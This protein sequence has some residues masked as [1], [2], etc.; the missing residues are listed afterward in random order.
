[1]PP[2]AS[3]LTSCGLVRHFRQPAVDTSSM[4][5]EN[6]GRR[7]PD[8]IVVFTVLGSLFGL[9][10]LVAFSAGQVGG[11]LLAGLGCFFW[12]YEALS[13]RP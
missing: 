4:P 11:G 3:I 12:I 2:L 10:A 6:G 9:A 1:M 5:R 7:D 8:E 13:T